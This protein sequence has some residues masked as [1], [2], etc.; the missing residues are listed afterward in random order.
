MLYQ[1][2][3]SLFLSNINT[4]QPLTTEGKSGPSS[5]R[6]IVC[7]V[8]WPYQEKGIHFVTDEACNITEVKLLMQGP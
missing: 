8:D 6:S 2:F 1:L 5:P 3:L 4:S 7:G